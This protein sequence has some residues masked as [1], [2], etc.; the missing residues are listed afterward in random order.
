MIC[1]TFYC[2]IFTVLSLK[3]TLTTAVTLATNID[4][5]LS[6]VFLII[7]YI[8]TFSVETYKHCSISLIPIHTFL[9][10]IILYAVFRVCVFMWA[11]VS[12]VTKRL[13]QSVTGEGV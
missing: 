8:N 13:Q 11:T 5:L 3:V 6:E 2:L 1:S 10:N 9:F 7:N 12:V 4:K